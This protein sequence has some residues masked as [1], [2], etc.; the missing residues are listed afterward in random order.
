MEKSSQEY[1]KALPPALITVEKIYHLW[2]YVAFVYFT[3]NQ[4]KIEIISISYQNFQMRRR[5]G[6]T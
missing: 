3:H 4:V 2:I 1:I 6:M 5:P